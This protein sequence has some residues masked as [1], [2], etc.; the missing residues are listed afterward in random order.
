MANE[1]INDVE[2]METSAVGIPAYPDAINKELLI[3]K[4]KVTAMEEKR[5]QLGM[6]ESEFYAFPRLKKLPIFD[7]A[8]VRNAMARKEN[9]L[10]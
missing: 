1:I 10:Q 9:S 6:S 3:E 8:H 5:K 2:L 7:E 4:A